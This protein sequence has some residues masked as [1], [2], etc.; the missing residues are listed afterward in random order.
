ME[1][2]ENAAGSRSIALLVVRR[3]AFLSL[4]TALIALFFWTAGS[5][6]LFL[7]ET[8]IML[9]SVLRWSSIALFILSFA[10][11][12][13]SLVEAGS[14]SRPRIL[15]SWLLLAGAAALLCLVS[16]VLILLSEGIA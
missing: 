16:E 10:A 12:A 9:L 14:R 8:Q 7:D 2:L 15:V 1:K 4:Y 11:A 13:G 6:R 5:F 3:L